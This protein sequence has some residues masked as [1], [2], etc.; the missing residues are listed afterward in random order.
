MVGYTPQ[1][2]AAVWVGSGNSTTPIVNAYGAPEYG[3]DLPG[4]TWALF[5]NTYLAGK[6]NLPMATKQMITGGES[7]REGAHARPP[8]TTKAADA[9]VH[10]ARPAS[11]RCRH[12]GPS[13]LDHVDAAAASAD[14]RRA[15][16]C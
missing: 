5:M 10:A 11:R 1:V 14:R 6:P 15:V 4:K 9:D 2:S 8:S 16:R 3:R 7:T 13:T 12:P